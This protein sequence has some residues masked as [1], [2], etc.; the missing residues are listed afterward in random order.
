MHT[1]LDD[2]INDLEDTKENLKVPH[3][4]AACAH[5]EEESL[6]RAND[7]ELTQDLLVLIY[8]EEEEEEEEED[9]EEEEE[10]E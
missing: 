4:I 6:E 2:G 8:E 9:E 1:K 3:G 5:R 10:E 7:T